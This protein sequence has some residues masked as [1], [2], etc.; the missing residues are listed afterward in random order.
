MNF[1]R[2]VWEDV[3]KVQLAIER[4]DWES[5]DSIRDIIRDYTDIESL[6]IACKTAGLPDEMALRELRCQIAASGAEHLEEDALEVIKLAT[7]QNDYRSLLMKLSRLHKFDAFAFV[8]LLQLECGPSHVKEVRSLLES[9]DE[10]EINI[11]A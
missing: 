5:A 4:N 2:Q 9:M 11:S 10:S 3:T 8:Y 1:R 7:K 6:W